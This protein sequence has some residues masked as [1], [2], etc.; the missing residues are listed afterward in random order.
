M[1]GLPKKVVEAS[2]LGFDSP[3]V[4]KGDDDGRAKGLLFE[5]VSFSFSC[6]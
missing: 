2:G 3:N 4:V 5:A 1:L 6:A